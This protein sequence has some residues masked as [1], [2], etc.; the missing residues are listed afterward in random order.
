MVEGGAGLVGVD[1]G[2]EAEGA[3]ERAP[4]QLTTQEVPRLR[5]SGWLGLAA[6]GEEITLDR[7]I[8]VG[9]VDARDGRGHDEVA[10]ALADV[11]SE[12]EG[13]GRIGGT[14]R[15]GAAGET[16][17]EEL[18][19]RGASALELR[20]GAEADE[21]G[22]HGSC[23]LGICGDATIIAPLHENVK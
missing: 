9:G 4:A 18:L 10:G 5:R 7:D 6:D 12:G 19:H 16:G 17:V 1:A 14:A 21:G 22:S 3:F 11:E 23:L 15:Q 8:E 20:E 13:G 2:R